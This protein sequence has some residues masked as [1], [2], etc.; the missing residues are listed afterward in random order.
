[1]VFTLLVFIIPA[2]LPFLLSKREEAVLYLF[3]D[4]HNYH[5]DIISLF[6]IFEESD[7]YQNLRKARA[8]LCSS[9]LERLGEALCSSFSKSF[10]S[11]NISDRQGLCLDDL[12]RPHLPSS[13]P[14][15]LLRKARSRNDREE[16]VLQNK[17]KLHILQFNNRIILNNNKFYS[18][19]FL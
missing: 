7:Y 5:I 8:V 15:F 6:N 11:I 14:C 1:M 9:P 17:A 19:F 16:A 2:S 13:S 3:T 18:F 12:L 4:P 10:Y